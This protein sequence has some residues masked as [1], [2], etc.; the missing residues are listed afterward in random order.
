MTWRTL[1]MLSRQLGGS[2]SSGGGWEEE[3]RLPSNCVFLRVGLVREVQDWM[4][5]R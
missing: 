1:F 5:R 4:L 3:G 2:W